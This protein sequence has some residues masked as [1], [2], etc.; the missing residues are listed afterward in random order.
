MYLFDAV[1]SELQNVMPFLI[2][3]D[4]HAYFLDFQFELFS[5]FLKFYDRMC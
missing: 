1:I 4:C 2:N 5:Y 3:I